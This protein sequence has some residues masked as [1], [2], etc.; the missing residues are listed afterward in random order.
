M[1]INTQLIED[2]IKEVIRNKLSAWNPESRYMPFHYRLLGEERMIEYSFIHSV[3]TRF[4]SSIFEPLAAK[5]AQERELFIDVSV[6]KDLGKEIS[7]KAQQEI[8]RIIDDID[9][10]G[11]ADKKHEIKIIRSL[12]DKGDMVHTRTAKVDIFLRDKHGKVYLFDLKTVKPNK[13]SIVSYK[14]TLLKWT[15]KYLSSDINAD[16]NSYIAFPYNPYHP[17]PYS[18]WT[19]DNILDTKN[20][21]KV[22][23]DFWDFIG[24]EG[25]YEALLQCFSN[26]G[27][28]LKQE[29]NSY[30]R[31]NFKN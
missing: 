7:N 21:L 5:I 4:G 25:T 3:N 16:V 11:R 1:P 13:D 9:N 26:A 28:E 6:Q 29:I 22:G 24:G 15:A 2:L 18:R 10:V 17:N 30:F 19:L 31:D 12:A 27:K 23:K 8:E 20:E 14:R